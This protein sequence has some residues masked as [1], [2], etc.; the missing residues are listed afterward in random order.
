MCSKT[1]L[2]FVE[3]SL[4]VE[5]VVYKRVLE[6]GSRIVKNMSARAYIESLKPEV[7]LGVDIE[8]GPGV[9]EICDVVELEDHYGVG[10]FDV[11]VCTEML[12][13][14]RD[15][16]KA[17]NNL[18]VVLAPGG[19]LVLTTRSKRFAYHGY[20]EDWWR[21]SPGDMKFIFSDFNMIRLARD[22]KQSG[23]FVCVEKPLGEYGPV[24]LGG[25]AVCSV[26]TRRRTACGPDALP[27][28]RKAAFAEHAV[29]TGHE[30]LKEISSPE[31]GLCNDRSCLRC[32]FTD[33]LN[34]IEKK[35]VMN[36]MEK[37]VK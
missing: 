36:C 37:E 25:F 3:E 23:V 29:K 15:W 9:D 20:P 31:H 32:R 33:I 13:H 27:A 28:L 34:E 5:Q 6:V 1:V 7:Y 12:E 22:P 2:K 14:V 30:F 35:Y 24:D 26:L 21:F 17:V 16:R 18:K 10:D 11:V 19:R 4:P 8:A